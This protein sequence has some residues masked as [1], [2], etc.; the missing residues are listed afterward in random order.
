[1][2]M[3]AVIVIASVILVVDQ[4]SQVSIRIFV[5]CFFVSFGVQVFVGLHLLVTRQEGVLF[6]K[7][8]GV[9]VQ[10]I[11]S[12]R[13]SV[14]YFCTAAILIPEDLY[15][16]NDTG[17][18]VPEYWYCTGVIVP[19]FYTI[20]SSIYYLRW[21]IDTGVFILEYRYRSVEYRYW[22]V[23]TGVFILPEH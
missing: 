1:M 10:E 22:S 18:L 17:V 13:V 3:I 23:Y 20:S 21:S 5:F 9:L 11:A 15:Q 19:E 7:D 2:I 6:L 14:A 12:V 16:S 4:R 8:Q